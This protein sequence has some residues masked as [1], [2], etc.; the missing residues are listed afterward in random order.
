MT[1]R[2]TGAMLL[3]S[4]PPVYGPASVFREDATLL[5]RSSSQVSKEKLA[6]Q[7]FYNTASQSGKFYGYEGMGY[8]GSA[9]GYNVFVNWQGS[10]IAVYYVSPSTP[11]VKVWLVEEGGS[12]E[13]P[14]G[15][16]ADEHL[17][18]FWEEVPVPNVALIPNRQIWPIGGDKST[19]VICPATGEM[20][21]L[22]RLGQFKK[23]TQMGEFKAT[24]G[25]YC[26]SIAGFNGIWPNQWGIAGSGL[27]LLGGIVTMQDIVRMLRGESLGHALRLAVCVATS[28][29]V[30]PA[31]R[32]NEV[33]NEYPFLEDGK[34]S[35]PA[36]GTV[37]AVPMGLW[38]AFPPSS[39]ASEYGITTPIASKLYE[40]MREHGLVVADG[41]TRGVN[42]DLA[43]PRVLGTPYSSTFINPFAGATYTREAPERE[44][45]INN[46]VP[47]SWTDPTL[48]AMTENLNG[49]GSVFSAMPWRDLEQLEPR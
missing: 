47:T 5:A 4:R 23:G 49:P 42:F 26:G 48:S 29:H 13:T 1:M 11:R 36:H 20:W 44:S 19:I 40:A 39:R 2:A 7:C 31:T 12:E 33:E 17:Q 41:T 14:R 18:S 35:N 6:N 28:E 10:T 32:N 46:L 45:Y 22:W 34:T 27:G 30:E 3:P 15:S 16:G 25:G 24:Y 9:E 38:C 43:D 37:D 8:G 21:E